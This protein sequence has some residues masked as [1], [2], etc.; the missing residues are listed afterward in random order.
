MDALALVDTIPGWLRAQD[1]DRLY[2]LACTTAGPVLEIGTYQGKSAVL[3]ALALREAGR[4]TTLFTVD[5][6]QRSLGAAARHAAA[7]GVA[8]LIVFVRGTSTA[9]AR[10]YPHLR[11]TLIFV[12][13]DHSQGGVARDLAALESLVPAGAQIVFHDFNDPLNADPS[14]PQ[15][16]VRDAVEA[17]WVAR[18]C[19][20][21]GVT[22]ACGLFTR[23]SAPSAPSLCLVDLLPL[24]RVT[25][26]L[27][28]R[29]R[30][31]AARLW[32]RLHRRSDNS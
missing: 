27:R 14:C 25:D 20:F 5:V 2:Q 13:A 12:D 3:M 10:A 24:D 19:E 29:F 26:Q 32:R 11:P 31:P 22:G 9:L 16:Q 8:D 23:R 21:A 15:V 30:L 7:H 1:A 28:Y 6:D 18:E 4:D 17:S